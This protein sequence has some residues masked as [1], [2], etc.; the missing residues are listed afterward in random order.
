MLDGP[1]TAILTV[2]ASLL[3]VGLIASSFLW[4]LRST[5]Q[6]EPREP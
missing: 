5:R 3:A 1:L 4:A 2:G 6:D